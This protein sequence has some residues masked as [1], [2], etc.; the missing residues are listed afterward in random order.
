MLKNW[1]SLSAAPLMRESLD[2]ILRM[3]ASVNMGEEP[4][5]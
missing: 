1:P 2:T 4:D 5:A 3:L